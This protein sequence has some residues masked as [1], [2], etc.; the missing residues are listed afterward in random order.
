MIKHETPKKKNESEEHRFFHGNR[1]GQ[2]NTGTGTRRVTLVSNPLT[3]H[4]EGMDEI[5]I[6]IDGT[7]P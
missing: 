7:H 3:C 6:M 2:H 4:E 1:S 5:V